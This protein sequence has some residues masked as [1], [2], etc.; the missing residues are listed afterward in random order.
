MEGSQ[1]HRDGCLHD[2]RCPSF[3]ITPGETYYLG[4]KDLR[5][6]FPAA[7]QRRGIL[8]ALGPLQAPYLLII[9]RAAS[10]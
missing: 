2:H 7:N 1:G 8:I 9:A 3:A 6:M 5:R 4:K 10:C